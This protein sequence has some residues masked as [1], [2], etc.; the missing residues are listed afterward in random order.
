MNYIITALDAEA[1][2]LIDH[3]KLKRNRVLPYTLYT[4]DTTVLLITGMGKLNAA[5]AVSALL[6]WRIPSDQDILINIGICGAPAVY[7]LGEALLIH[8]IHSDN[9]RYYPDILYTHP[10][11]ESSII[12]VDEAQNTLHPFP[13]DMES[14]GIFQASSRFFKLHKMAFIK[15]VSDH[16]TPDSVTKEG[17][18][19]LIQ[20]H[21]QNVDQLITSLQMIPSDTVYFMEE[22][23]TLIQ[24]WKGYF[25]AAQGVKFE[26]ALLYFRLKY[27]HRPFPFPNETIP[28]S[29]QERSLL[30]E[31]FINT[32][33]S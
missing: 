21:L 7:P 4:N 28:L 14:G 26:D 12:C 30:L 25:T 3:Y 29:K 16:F 18:I 10:F 15:I 22:E 6:G 33:V 2:A 19:S 23:N 5:M 1:R 9:R 13:I 17:V 31:R 8:Q 11:Q 27:P 24:M 32:L 20:S